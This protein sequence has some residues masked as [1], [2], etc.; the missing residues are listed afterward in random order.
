MHFKPIAFFTITET[1][2]ISSILKPEDSGSFIN[3]PYF[4]GN[5]RVC[6]NFDNED[7]YI[8]NYDEKIISIS[9]SLNQ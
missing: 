9:N 8:N 7:L 1:P 2:D 6:I 5:S 3:L 4:N